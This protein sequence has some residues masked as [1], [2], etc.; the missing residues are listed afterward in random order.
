MCLWYSEEWWFYSCF[1]NR[2]F[3]FQNY[4]SS[5]FSLIHLIPQYDRNKRKSWNTIAFTIEQSLNTWVMSIKLS[6]HINPQYLDPE[7]LRAIRK[8]LYVEPY[9]KYVILD[10][11]FL[12]EFYNELVTIL[13]NKKWRMYF[14][15]NMAPEYK[16]WKKF[17]QRSQE[18]W[19]LENIFLGQG[20]S[21]FTQ[22]IF[23]K[24]CRL[25][26]YAIENKIANF[27]R[28]FFPLQWAV[29]HSYRRDDFLEWHTD[30]PIWYAIGSMVYFMGNDWKE[31]YGGQLQLWKKIHPNDPDSHVMPYK[32]I[33]PKWNRLVLL[34]TEYNISWH[35]VLP[36]V[37]T[38][39][40]R[41][42]FH[43][44]FFI[45]DYIPWR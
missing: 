31:D 35:R 13:Q 4:I 33:E 18:F 45:P 30:G 2:Y 10:D 11:F 27:I 38:S 15:A 19:V 34:L 5:F 44:Q 42:S 24:K 40:E 16:K 7:N 41:I 3:T 17:F 9:V 25:Q 39:F 1:K 6:T 8:D 28:R 12:P 43:E 36:I 21:A 37:D 22:R 29:L 14:N 26:T 23:A 20:F 32:N